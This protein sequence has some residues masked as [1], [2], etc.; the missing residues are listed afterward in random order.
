MSMIRDP[1]DKGLGGGGWET[2]GRMRENVQTETERG[3]LVGFVF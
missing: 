3:G 2:Q 1:G